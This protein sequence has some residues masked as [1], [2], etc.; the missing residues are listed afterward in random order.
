MIRAV[1]VPAL[2]LMPAL[3]QASTPITEAELVR[4]TQELY[5]AVAPG[6]KAPWQRYYA[7]DC[8]FFDEKGRS[9]D[10]AALVADVAPLPKGYGGAI[11]VVH[12]KSRIFKQVAILSYDADETET[13]FGQRLSARYHTTDTWMLRKGEWR[14][15]ASQTLRYYEDP[16]Q[17]QTDPARF[18]DY[19]GT[20]E[21]SPGNRM[22][23]GV[24]N[25]ALVMQRGQRPQVELFPEG[26]PVFFRKGVEGRIVFH[27]DAAGKADVLLE[28]RNHE[29]VVWKRVE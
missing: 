4:R 9:M 28:R 5:D 15:V 27:L 3:A 14:I 2:L 25:G 26:G 24:E 10:K 6:D 13:I 22:T 12:P 29:D 20:Y 16:A 17:G 23:V 19:T 21:L 18:E 1:L 8:L 11:R 7:D